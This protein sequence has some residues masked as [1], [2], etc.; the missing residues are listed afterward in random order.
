MWTVGV[1]WRGLDACHHQHS[2]KAAL[3]SARLSPL[4]EYPNER[5]YPDVKRL[6]VPLHRW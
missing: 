6:A 5:S 2:H 1:S 4:T 3:I